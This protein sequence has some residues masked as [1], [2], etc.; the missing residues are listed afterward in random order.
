[1]SLLTIGRVLRKKRKL[2]HG[3]KK[4]CGR[5]TP[6]EKI[7]MAEVRVSFLANGMTPTEFGIGF[8]ISV[9]IIGYRGKF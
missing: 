3:E 8:I 4:K 1:M 6:T 5:L 7:Q 9:L 2:L